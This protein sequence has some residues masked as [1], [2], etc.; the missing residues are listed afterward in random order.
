VNEG[1]YA[2]AM[3]A[4]DEEAPV[5]GTD[6]I[7]GE[8]SIGAR[9]GSRPC[10]QQEHAGLPVGRRGR[11]RVYDVELV[12]DPFPIETRWAA[13]QVPFVARQQVVVSAPKMLLGSSVGFS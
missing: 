9:V 1:D 4:V 2:L 5:D 7:L 10:T 12:R 13:L 8:P 3:G 6:G 11:R